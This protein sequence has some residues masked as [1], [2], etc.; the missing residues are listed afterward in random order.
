[1]VVARQI[2]TNFSSGELNPLMR[3]RSDTGAYQNGAARLRNIALLNTGGVTRRP[4][5]TYL[6]TLPA[7]SRLVSFDFDDNERYIFALSNAKLT[8]YDVNGALIAT[9]TSGATW[10]TASCL[11]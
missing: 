2:Q 7:R 4:G 3:F 9:V 10:T 8:V 6:A 1:M 5:T 11:N